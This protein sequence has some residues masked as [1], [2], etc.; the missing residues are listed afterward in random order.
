MFETLVDQV[1]LVNTPEQL[2]TR[3]LRHLYFFHVEQVAD[4]FSLSQL[5]L[6]FTDIY[7]QSILILLTIEFKKKTTLTR[8]PALA[9]Y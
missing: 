6:N 1:E 4:L 7:S 5:G 8:T 9:I 2:V 3:I